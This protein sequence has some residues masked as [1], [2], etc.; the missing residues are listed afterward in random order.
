MKATLSVLIALA[1]LFSSG[2]YADAESYCQLKFRAHTDTFILFSKGSGRGK[3]T[4]YEGSQPVSEAEVN[5]SID[6]FGPGL[7]AFDVRGESE[8]IA[9]SS[10]EQLE[11][12]YFVGQ[13]AIGAGDAAGDVMGFKSEQSELAFQTRMHSV[14]GGGLMLNAT[15]WTITLE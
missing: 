10:P 9:I 5:I 12:S 14:R 6:G 4:C 15:R 7:G 13:G 1:G 8:H 3:V 11:G 2:A